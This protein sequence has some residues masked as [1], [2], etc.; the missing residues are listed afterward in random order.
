MRTKSRPFETEFVLFFGA[1]LFVRV[2]LPAAV[3]DMFVPYTAS[4]GFIA[5]KIHPGT[6]LLFTAAAWEIVRSNVATL[7]DYRRHGPL[8]VMCAAAVVAALSAIVQGRMNAIGYLVDSIFCGAIAAWLMSRIKPEDRARIITAIVAGLAV[9]TLISAYEWVTH[10]RVLPFRY[11]E[12]TF[13]PTG[14]FDH[15]LDNGLITATVMMCIPSLRWPF[16]IT[17]GTMMFFLVGVFISGARAATLVSCVIFAIAFINLMRREARRG[18][19]QAGMVMVG[20]FAV[21]LIAPIIL[22][23]GAL[24]SLTYRL[25]E[26]LMDKSAMTRIDI[27]GVLQY[28]S[29]GELL[30]G[31]D[32]EKLNMLSRVF[33][34]NSA[35]ES[36]IVMMIFQFGLIVMVILFGS[37]L[38]AI[39][40]SARRRRGVLL[41][42]IGFILIANTNN[43]LN[44]KSQALSLVLALI[45]AA[46]ML[47]TSSA[48]ARNARRPRPT[49]PPRTRTRKRV[50][51][52]A[53]PPQTPPLAPDPSP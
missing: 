49:L 44:V 5:F 16:I 31:S 27:F 17:I 11:R 20:V 14:L 25:Q 45:C 23:S 41:A 34:R 35:I 42:A 10:N 26:K 29:L 3:V 36:P 18:G 53:P 39:G 52:V 33:L 6:Y 2:F 30:F 13:R 22:A 40:E 15:P 32:I 9:H 1:A 38:Y 4:N 7:I 19:K 21:L 47:Q 12:E 51:P 48:P 28:L 37:I 43:V 50:A 46:P 24:D 8:L